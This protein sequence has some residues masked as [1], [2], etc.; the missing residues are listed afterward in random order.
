MFVASQFTGLEGR[1]LTLKETVDS[2]KA[3]L[4]GEYDEYP[5]Q[6]FYNVGTIEE[7][8]AKAKTLGG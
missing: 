8:V 1:Y 3:L 7:A 2:F 5:E 6:A 4:S